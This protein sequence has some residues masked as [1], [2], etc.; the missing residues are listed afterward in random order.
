MARALVKSDPKSLE[1][2]IS[3]IKAGNRP[4]SIPLTDRQ[5]EYTDYQALGFVL[6][7]TVLR[8]MTPWEISFAASMISTSHPSAKQRERAK[9]ILKIYLG[10][11]I[12]AGTT[13]SSGV[14]NDNAP[15]TASTRRKKSA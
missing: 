15:A 4:V 3:D 13:P 10:L 6:L 9:I 14:A 7:E 11:D 12:D 8:Q 2:A 5:P 1:I